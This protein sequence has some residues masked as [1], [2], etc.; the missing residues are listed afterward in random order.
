[1]ICFCL[2]NVLSRSGFLF[3]RCTCHSSCF[4]RLHS[5]LV[6]FYSLYAGTVKMYLPNPKRNCTYKLRNCRRWCSLQLL[7]KRSA[8]LQNKASRWDRV[9]FNLNKKAVVNMAGTTA[10]KK[11][12]GDKT[13]VLHSASTFRHLIFSG[14]LSYLSPPRT[15]GTAEAKND[16]T[17]CGEPRADRVCMC[18]CVYCYC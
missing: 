14:L 7:I 1:M 5:T 9:S 10:E 16:D 6:L 12:V 17:L 8:S 3:Q 18:V 2:C 11:G 4:C 13:A 15:V